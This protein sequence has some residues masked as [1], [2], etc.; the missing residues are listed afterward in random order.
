MIFQV[1][2]VPL[3]RMTRN[4]TSCGK[5]PEINIT[6]STASSFFIFYVSHATLVFVRH[7]LDL[8]GL[9]LSPYNSWMMKVCPLRVASSDC[10]LER[11]SFAI[12]QVGQSLLWLVAYFWHFARPALVISLDPHFQRTF[13]CLT[14]AGCRS[15]EEE[16]ESDAKQVEMSLLRNSKEPR[17]NLQ[18]REETLQLFVPP[19][20]DAGHAVDLA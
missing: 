19:S 3:R 16:A 14:F 20:G 9:A 4:Q 5:Q 12:S 1:S 15:H 6:L 17:K 2:I 11:F 13:G 7:T 18:H 8:A 10:P